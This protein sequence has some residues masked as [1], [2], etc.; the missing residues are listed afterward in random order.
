MKSISTRRDALLIEGLGPSLAAKSL[1]RKWLFNKSP[2]SEAT[3]P[4]IHRGLCKGISQQNMVLYGTVITSILGSWN[5]HWQN[6]CPKLLGCLFRRDV[7]DLWWILVVFKDVFHGHRATVGSL[8]WKSKSCG[9][10]TMRLFGVSRLQWSQGSSGFPWQSIPSP[11]KPEDHQ[12]GWSTAAAQIYPLVIADIAIE[13]DHRNS[14][15]S[16]W[17]WWIFP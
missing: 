15:F 11:F 17:K 13:N 14:G 1:D 4:E 9:Y 6:L 16:H 12:E 8:S 5:S 7:S 10:E 3:W 2:E